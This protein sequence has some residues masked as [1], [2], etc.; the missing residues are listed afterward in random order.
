MRANTPFSSVPAVITYFEAPDKEGP[1]Y[2]DSVDKLLAIYGSENTP[3]Y[4][5][6]THDAAED[7]IISGFEA[8]GL[9]RSRLE[10]VVECEE[11]H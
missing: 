11:S 2:K 8:L 6:I 5:K 3:Y 4:D 1:E 7:F 9:E 10:F